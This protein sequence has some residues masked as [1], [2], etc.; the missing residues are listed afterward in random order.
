MPQVGRPCAAPV[1]ARQ[2]VAIKG[3]N[4]AA[5]PYISP[6]QLGK[7]FSHSSGQRRY[8]SFRDIESHVLLNL[9]EIE[10]AGYACV[11][12]IAR[13]GL[14]AGAMLSQYSG[15]P[16]EVASFDR[17]TRTV[18]STLA[19]PATDCRKLL[20]VDDIAGKGWTLA[21]VKE[22][23]E[24]LGWT[25]DTF[26]N[27]WDSLSRTI[28]TYGV[29]LLGERPVWPWERG[30]FSD[31]L[32]VDRRAPDRDAWI[33]GFDL[34]GVFLRDVDSALYVT[35][36]PLALAQR[37]A[38]PAFERRPSL[39]S[40]DGSAAIISARLVSE[41]AETEAWLMRHGLRAKQVV[42]RDSLDI[43]PAV[44]KARAILRLGVTEFVESELDQAKQIAELAPYCVVWH[45]DEHDG[46][47][48]RQ[49]H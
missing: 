39:W 49:D 42:L 11:V 2:A 27:A 21:T 17:S 9:P 8:F 14:Y 1:N 30:I 33:R 32:A 13:G 18:R 10:T 5:Q 26:T 7:T 28:P 23:F 20:L 25:V 12:A 43:P 22:H 16:M 48:Y 19:G 4:Q 3:M 31:E 37:D 29:Q 40:N 6:C 45:Y 47:L 36:L 41:Q 35:D 15:V 24:Q 46:R 44:H 34:D 38:L